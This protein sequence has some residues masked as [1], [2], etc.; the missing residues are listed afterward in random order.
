MKILLDFDSNNLP[1]KYSKYA[2][3]NE[4]YMDNPIV[5]FPFRI[6]EVSPSVKYFAI[7]LIDY[8]SIPVCGFA[9][10]HWTVANIPVSLTEIP[11]NFSQNETYKK[12]QGTNSFASALVNET[13]PKIIHRYVGPTPPDKDHCYKLTLYALSEKLDLTEG[14]YMNELYHQMQDKIIAKTSINIIGNK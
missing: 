10:I 2:G 13:D 8:D 11:E 6:T 12:I 1:Q 9:W 3:E 5:S 4:K 7:T 14:F